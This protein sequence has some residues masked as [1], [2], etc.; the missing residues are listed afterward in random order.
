MKRQT[1]CQL[2]LSSQTLRGPPVHDGCLHKKPEIGPS[3]IFYPLMKNALYRLLI[4]R[5]ALHQH[6][7]RKA[8][9]WMQP[10]DASQPSISAKPHS[11]LGISDSRSLMATFVPRAKGRETKSVTHRLSLGPSVTD[12]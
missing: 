7:P 2:P 9:P 1:S 10:Q 12:L 6:L 8:A 11:A 5:Q 3:L 4:E